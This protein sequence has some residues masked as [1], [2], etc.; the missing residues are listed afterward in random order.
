MTDDRSD[1][2]RRHRRRRVLRDLADSRGARPRAAR[3][4]R[5]PATAASPSR[6]TQKT[7]LALS[8]FDAY[9]RDGRVLVFGESEVRYLESARRRPSGPRVLRRVLGHDTPVPARHRRLRAA[10]RAGRSKPT[11]AGCR[12]CAPAPRRR[13]AMSRLSARAR[14]LPRGPRRRPR[15]ADGHPRARRARH[16]R[17]RHRQERVRARPRRPRPPAGR[18]RRGRG[19][20]PGRVVRARQLPGADAAPHG[21][22][23]PRADQRAGPVRRRLDADVEAG[24]A[25]RAARA[26][27]ARPRVRSARPRR[28]ALRDA[29][30]PHPDDPDAGRAR[31]QRRHPRRGR[32][33]QPAA[34]RRRPSRGAAPRRAPERQLEAAARRSDSDSATT[35]EDARH[36]GRCQIRRTAEA[37]KGEHVR[38]KRHAARRAARTAVTLAVRR[39]HRAVG[40]GQVAGDPGARGSRLLLRRQPAGHAAADARRADAARRQRDLPAPRSSSTCARGSCSRI[41]RHL[42]APQG[43]AQPASGADLPRSRATTRWCAGSARRGGRTRWRRTARRSRASARSARRCARSASSPTTSSTRRR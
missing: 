9:L 15:R 38:E 37:T 14:H 24:R 18:R 20:A 40:I 6:I 16:R 11:A 35:S 43:D 7:G 21:D 17:E 1:A 41:S 26:L 34:A 25:R 36:D 30:H 28:R 19:A 29:R 27:G 10:A 39:A 12:C 32:G 31:P 22:P 2:R 5:R 4:R 23:R 42:S 33:A 3:R 8:G 13:E